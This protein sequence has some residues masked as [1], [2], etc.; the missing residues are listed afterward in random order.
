MPE[1]YI[2]W[3]LV[4]I[5]SGLQYA[6]DRDI[7]H[8]DMKPENIFVSEDGWL[9]LG[10]LGIC[11]VLVT[12]A[13]KITANQK[14]GTVYYMPPECFQNKP[15]STASDI[16]ATGC[17]LHWVMK[18]N[19]LFKADAKTEN[20]NAKI[21]ERIEKHVPCRLPESYSRTLKFYTWLMLQKDPAKRPPAKEV[22]ESF[23]SLADLSG[24]EVELFEPQGPTMDTKTSILT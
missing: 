21:E 10:D 19:T 17:I 20:T 5:M 22:L 3:Y 14:T 15:A 18:G 23:S 16:W 7:F 13:G 12:T 24:T 9:K 1:S 8:S 11:K 6:H 2:I 4:Q